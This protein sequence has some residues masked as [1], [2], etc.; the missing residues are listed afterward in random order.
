MDAKA[1]GF[2]S[3]AHYTVLRRQDVVLDSDVQDAIPHR[4]KRGRPLGGGGEFAK[5]VRSVQRSG[6]IGQVPLVLVAGVVLDFGVVPWDRPGYFSSEYFFPIG[7]RAQRLYPT[8]TTRV[9]IEMTILDGGSKVQA[10]LFFFFF[11]F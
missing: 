10:V 3:V 6:S 2:L 7:Y 9:V 1:A 11:P 4:G 8:D 5:R